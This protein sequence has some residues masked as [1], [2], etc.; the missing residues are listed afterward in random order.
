MQ[1]PFLVIAECGITLDN[2]KII[3]LQF[4]FS[5]FLQVGT[6]EKKQK[7]QQQQQPIIYLVAIAEADQPTVAAR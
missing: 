7:Q 1:C 4:I 6:F 5:L 2:V 3:P